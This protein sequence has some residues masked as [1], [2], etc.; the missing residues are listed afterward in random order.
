MRRKTALVVLICVLVLTADISFAA[1]R[2]EG[3]VFRQSKDE[4]E[5][6]IC[7]VITTSRK[8]DEVRI[9]SGEFPVTPGDCISYEIYVRNLSRSRVRVITAADF[10]FRRLGRDF[11]YS[12]EPEKFEGAF[13]RVAPSRLDIVE[14]NSGE[15]AHLGSAEYTCGKKEVGENTFSYSISSVIGDDYEVWSGIILCRT[16]FRFAG[17]PESVGSG[18]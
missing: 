2:I 10:G 13:V 6:I 9:Q 18:E 4:I 3:P 16:P 14:L 8:P 7:S 5:L 15:I 1:L 17:G 12:C 11:S